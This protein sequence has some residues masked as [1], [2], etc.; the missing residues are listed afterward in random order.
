MTLHSYL[1]FVLAS[2]VLCIVPGPDMA[3]LLGRSIAQGR[4]AG[5]LAAVGINLGGYVHLTASIL[6]LSAILAASSF[7]FTLVKWAGALYLIYLGIRAL[8]TKATDLQLD[9]SNSKPLNHSA[10]FWQGF[11]SDVLNPKVAMFFLAFLPQF[12]DPHENPVPQ[13][14]LLGLTVNMIAIVL[15]VL[16]VF[17][18]SSLTRKLRGNGA[19]NAWLHKAMGALF[20]ALGLRLAAEKT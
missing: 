11:V 19:I 13:L 8:R 6:G 18:S 5:V 10:I 3:F 2:I 9:T 20:V 14:L 7:A 1:L 4:K 12:V 17:L 15:N 16:L